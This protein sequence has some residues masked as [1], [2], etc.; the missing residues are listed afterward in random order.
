[1]S[2]HELVR[3]DLQILKPRARQAA[4]FAN[5]HKKGQGTGTLR[6]ATPEVREWLKNNIKNHWYFFEDKSGKLYIAFCEKKDAM[7]WK[8]A[9]H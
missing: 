1:M 5:R 4:T 9:W 6:T 7:L 8:L 3:A 2:H